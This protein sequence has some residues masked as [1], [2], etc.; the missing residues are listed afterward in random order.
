MKK[1]KTIYWISTGFIFL[2]QGILPALTGHTE[3]ARERILH[4][5]YPGYF[6]FLLNIF[7][8]LGAITLIVP[9]IP[10][11]LKEWS[12]AG[13]TFDFIFAFLSIFIVNGFSAA[14]FFPLIVL[15]VLMI[16]YFS[17]HK[18]LKTTKNKPYETQAV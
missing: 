15:G 7:K 10:E 14:V 1:L 11:R 6:I 2:F 9:K 17:Y 18:L 13:F 3:M 4:L 8:I 5:G 16:S 12:Y